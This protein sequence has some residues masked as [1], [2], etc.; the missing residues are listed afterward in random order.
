MVQAKDEMVREIIEYTKE[1]PK[2]L[3]NGY[4]INQVS[5]QIFFSHFHSKMQKVLNFVLSEKNIR[6]QQNIDKIQKL[7]K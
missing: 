7:S 5:E 4:N 2:L 6:F 3:F 1:V